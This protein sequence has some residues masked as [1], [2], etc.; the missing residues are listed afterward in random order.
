[1]QGPCHQCVDNTNNLEDGI[2][3]SQQS[4]TKTKNNFLYIWQRLRTQQN[5]RLLHIKMCWCIMENIIS[6][7]YY[8]N[9]SFLSY[10]TYYTRNPEQSQQT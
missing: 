2:A 1:M 7:M 5:I 8:L 3:G 9:P 10:G 6:R 4:P